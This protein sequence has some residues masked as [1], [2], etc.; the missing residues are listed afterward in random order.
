LWGS[1]LLGYF[2]LLR[3]SEYLIVGRTRTFYCLKIKDVFF[4]DSNGEPVDPEVASAVTIGL[5]GAKN[6]QYG[7]GAWRTMHKSGD[8][9]L[10]PVRALKH[11]TRARQELG[12]S[13]S[14][15]LAVDL[16]AKAVAD[17]L[18]ATAARAGVP[19]SRYSTHSLRS[20]GATALLTGKADS[21]AIKLLGRWMS[22]CYEEYPVQAASSTADLSRRMV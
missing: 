19:P 18:K 4:T 5:S 9:R 8:R 21:L 13:N 11:L 15:Y 2:F 22:R 20:G 7:R 1:V 17:A 16:T 3:R 10:C 14:K 6:D 12:V